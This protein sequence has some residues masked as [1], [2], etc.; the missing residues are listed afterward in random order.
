[1]SISDSISRALAD[2]GGAAAVEF[3]LLAPAL[4]LVVIGSVDVGALAYQKAE[5]SAAANAGALYAIHK[6]G[7]SPSSIQTAASSA[8]PLTLSATPTV[9]TLYYCSNGGALSAAASAGASC[10]AGKPTAGT[11]IQV[12]TQA[13][14]APPVSWTNLPMPTAL[15]ATTLVRIK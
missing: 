4:I 13:T 14:Y 12:T 9:S 1:M 8:T 6:G 11:Y 2:T 10:G 5:V 7:G 15:S 3:A